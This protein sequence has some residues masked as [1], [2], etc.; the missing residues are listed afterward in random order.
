MQ[1]ETVVTTFAL[2]LA[3]AV[4]FTPVVLAAELQEVAR[5]ELNRVDGEPKPPPVESLLLDKATGVIIIG[6]NHSLNFH[7]EPTAPEPEQ[8][9]TLSEIQVVFEVLPEEGEDVGECV[10][11]DY[12]FGGTSSLVATGAAEGR[13]G[14][15]GSTGTATANP[16]AI[17]FAGPSRIVQ[18]PG[19]GQVVIFSFGP[20]VRGTEDPDFDVSEEDSFVARIGDQVQVELTT[21]T[22]ADVP[23][24]DTLTGQLS[25]EIGA[26]V[27][28]GLVP[29]PVNLVEVPVNDAW[30]LG[31]LTLLLAA[32]GALLVRRGLS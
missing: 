29:C 20:Q 10:I 6:Q 3:M 19:V 28:E 14:I 2:L 17:S 24:G 32:G 9:T 4:P 7:P 31:A 5:T 22:A 30:S 1:V 13:L 11:V 23:P 21:A 25:V 27:Q 16:L 26:V 15:G 12:F 18:E 8:G